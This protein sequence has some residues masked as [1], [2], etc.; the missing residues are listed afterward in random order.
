MGKNGRKGSAGEKRL[1]GE[2]VEERRPPF[3][4]PPAQKSALEGTVM[5]TKAR[6]ELTLSTDG[7]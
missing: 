2:G 5:V 7:I 1:G 4:G 6:L 3:P